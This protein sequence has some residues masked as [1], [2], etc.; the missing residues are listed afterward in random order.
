MLLS[1]KS[2]VINIRKE[3]GIL[4]FSLLFFYI[5]ALWRCFQITII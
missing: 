4:I 5:M 3:Y 1:R 2:N